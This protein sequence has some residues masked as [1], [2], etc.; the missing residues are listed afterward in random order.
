[1]RARALHRVI[2]IILLLPFFGWALTGLV[3]FIKPGYEGAYEA[4]SPK[5]YPLERPVTVNPDPAWLEF[6][7]IKTVL[8]E[9]LLV[10]TDAGWS[11]LNP[12]DGRPRA[13]PT[14]DEIR[15]LLKDAFSANP[16]RYGNVTKVSGDTASTDTGVEVTVDWER[17]SLRQRGADTDRIDLLYKVHYLQW[18]GVTVID[19]V[20]GM[21]GIV[22][23][24]ALTVL[25]ARLAVK[26]G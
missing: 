22:M 13:Q 7:Y 21:V 17:L 5:T 12:A 11:H 20:A 24:L 6:R 4:L 8:G 23:V 18:T 16:R 14:E 10:R 2:G 9:H 26:R 15:A 19:R 1:M 3:F 25:G